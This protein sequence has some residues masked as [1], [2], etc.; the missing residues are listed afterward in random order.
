MQTTEFQN[1]IFR[2]GQFL[3]IDDNI[4]VCFYQRPQA[5]F[6]EEG[7]A[8]NNVSAFAVFIP[9]GLDQPKTRAT[10]TIAGKNDIEALY[11]IFR[12]I[13]F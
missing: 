10:S 2:P 9:F 3:K 7:Y 8:G 5:F 4:A 1:K 11:I 13:F 12:H 6:D